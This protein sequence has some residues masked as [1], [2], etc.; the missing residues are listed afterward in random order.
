MQTQTKLKL[1][2]SDYFELSKNTLDDYGAFNISL[3]ADLPLFIDPFLLF[4]SEKPEYQALHNAIIQ[5]LKYLRDLSLRQTIDYGRL[6]SLFYFSEVKQTYLGYTYTGNRGHGLGSRFAR[7]LNTNL[8]SIFKSFGKETITRGIH[9]EKLCLISAG[10]GRDTISDFVTNLIKEYLLKYTQEFADAN[11]QD[12]FKARFTLP[13]VK[14]NYQLGIWTSETF[15][16]PVFRDD[17]VILTPKDMLT[18]H[19]NWISRAEY[20]ADFR[21]IVEA[22]PDEQLRS[23]LDSYIVRRLSEKPT[24][25]EIQ[26]AYEDFTRLHPELIDYF[27]LFKENNGDKAVKRSAIYV[28]ESDLFFVQ[29]FGSLAQFLVTNTL[30]YQTGLKTKHETYK[31]IMFLKEAIEDKGCW[32]IFY[33]KDKPITREEDLHVLFRLVW[34]GTALDV[35]REVNNGIGPADFKV[36]YGYKDKTLVE[37]KLANNTHLKTQLQTQLE[38]YKKASDAGHGYKVVVYFNENQLARVKA[39]LEDLQME[40]D[41]S[42]IL[43]DARPRLSASKAR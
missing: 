34:Y 19:E 38:L 6:K 35:S 29:Q 24:L 17:Y 26:S 8:S 20:L 41:P 5:Y 15:T 12:K 10:V 27:I 1:Y 4:Q 33:N 21:T 11:I 30:F 43:I 14:F 42:I 18:R 2:F 37:F 7:A 22:A 32:K 13:R 28:S 16:L 36:S 3:I 31:R 23:D 25:E 40:H 9:L 39:I